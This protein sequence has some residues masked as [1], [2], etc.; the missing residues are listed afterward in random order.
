MQ[1]TKRHGSGQNIRETEVVGSAV[2][3]RNAKRGYTL[4]PA[5]PLCQPR[6]FSPGERVFKPAEM[7]RY[8]NSG[9]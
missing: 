4:I 1:I 8:K 9:L 2:F 7:P 6:T 3:V 5:N